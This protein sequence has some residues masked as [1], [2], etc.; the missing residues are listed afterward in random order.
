MLKKKYVLP[1]DKK[2][3]TFVGRLTK[4][5]RPLDFLRLAKSR[6]GHSDEY[7]VLVGDGELAAEAQAFIDKYGL[8]M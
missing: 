3:F 7:F 2:I 5:K 8:I 6:L 4:Q 1:V